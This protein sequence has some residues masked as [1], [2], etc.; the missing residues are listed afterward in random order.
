MLGLLEGLWELMDLCGGITRPCDYCGVLCALGFVL[1]LPAEVWIHLGLWNCSGALDGCGTGAVMEKA[2]KRERTPL[3]ATG[4]T[5]TLPWL[6][7]WML[8]V[9]K[10]VRQQEPSLMSWKPVQISTAVGC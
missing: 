6:C 1:G 10:G 5:G 2:G 7:V 3:Q 9:Q 8:G 4:R